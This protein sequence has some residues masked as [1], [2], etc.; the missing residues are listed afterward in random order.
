MKL[1]GLLSPAAF[2]MRH[3]ATI[4]NIKMIKRKNSEDLVLKFSGEWL[5]GDIPEG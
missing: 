4:S 5:G 1:E 2:Y 3:E